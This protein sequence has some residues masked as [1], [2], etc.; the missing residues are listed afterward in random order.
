MFRRLTMMLFLPPL[1][2]GNENSQRCPTKAFGSSIG[3]S[4][5]AL[6]GRLDESAALACLAYV[7]LNPVRAAIA[8]TR[9]LRLRLVP[10]RIR[11]P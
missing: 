11:T 9:G 3:V 5:I 4:D 6:A 8:E 7:D 2:R 1:S 10:R